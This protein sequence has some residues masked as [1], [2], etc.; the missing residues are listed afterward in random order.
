MEEGIRKSLD[1]G[2]LMVQNTALYEM[3][4]NTLSQITFCIID[5]RVC[6]GVCVCVPVCMCMRVLTSW[7]RSVH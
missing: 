2:E 1:G 4:L 5:I 6:G 3:I 7:C